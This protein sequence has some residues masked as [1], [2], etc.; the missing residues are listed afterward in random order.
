M[1]TIRA[2]GDICPGDTSIPGFGPGSVCLKKGPTHLFSP[3]GDHLKG[4]DILLGNLEGLLT[5]RLDRR[6]LQKL[7]FCGV[8]SLAKEL[9]TLGFTALSVANNHVLEH[10]PELFIETVSILKDNGLEVCGLRGESGFHCEPVVVERNGTKVGILA[11]NWIGTDRFPGADD[12]IA[13]IRDGAVNYTWNRDPAESAQLRQRAGELNAKVHEDVRRLRPDVD[14][15]VLCPHWGYEYSHVPPIGVTVEARSFLDSGADL[16]I[17]GHPHVLQ[18]HERYQGRMIFY[19][20]GNFIFDMSA[21]ESRRGVVLDV[22]IDGDGS[23][24]FDHQFTLLDGE[25]RPHRAPPKEQDALAELIRVS[26][27][28]IIDPEQ[29]HLLDDELIYGCYEEHYARGKRRKV[30]RLALAATRDPRIVVLI[31]KKV[32]FLGGLILR[33]IRGERVRW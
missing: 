33:R 31:M 29:A 2:V 17:G 25:H 30:V 18:G 15:V 9:R 13:Q 7:T 4:A 24:T 10:G 16:I 32:F 12:H 26:S 14:L 3:I 20:L 21:P 28:T 19:S 11:Y 23:Q 22:G 5:R 27:A 1:L 8:P 6:S